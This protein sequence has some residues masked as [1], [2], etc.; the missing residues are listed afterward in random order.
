MNSYE[1]EADN[2]HILTKFSIYLNEH[3]D[4]INAQMVESLSTEFDIPKNDALQMLLAGGLDMDVTDSPRDARIFREDFPRMIRPLDCR[5]F[6][7][8]PY[9]Q[10]IKI[11]DMHMDTCELAHETLKAYEM[12]VCDDRRDFPDGASLPQIGYFDQ[13]FSYPVLRENGR[14]WMSVTPCEAATVAPAARQAFGNALTLGLGLGYFMFLASENPNVQTV[15]AVEKNDSVI[16]L[17]NTCI[18]PQFPNKDKVR[19]LKGDAFE[20]TQQLYQ[21]GKYQFMFAD[22]W[23]DAG[24]GVPMYL[25]FKEM[26]KLNGNMKYC[27]WI[28]NTIRHYL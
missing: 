3:A 26:E 12:F 5:R 24:D 17:F 21:S 15:T 10:R 25:K 1:R 27:Y 11:P 19:I 16:E 7:S 18:L 13:D 22:T 23:H 8:D 2:A 14:T 28:E 6:Q 4:F 20:I 9:Y